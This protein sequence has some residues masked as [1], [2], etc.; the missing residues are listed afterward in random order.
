LIHYFDPLLAHAN[1]RRALETGFCSLKLHE[2]ELPA[3]RAAREEAGPDVELTLDVNCA[4]ILSEARTRAEE[5]KEFHLKWLE[6]PMWPP[7]N[8]D[9]LAQ[10]RRT[11][12]ISIAAR[13]ENAS[14]LKELDRLVGAG[15]VDFVQ[16]SVAKMGD[17]TELCKV[18][19]IA[20]VH[21]VTLMPHVLRRARPVGCDPG[22]GRAGDCGRND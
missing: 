13:A 12:G 2:I 16:P 15:A 22:D 14:T 6:E 18:F 8:Y 20:A 7:E 17:V 3:I 19:P 5:L 9:G 10:L 11:S 4:R 21:N 1:V